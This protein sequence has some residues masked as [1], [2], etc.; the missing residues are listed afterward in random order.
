MIKQTSDDDENEVE[1]KA[2]KPIS[3]IKKGDKIKVD[4][5][6][7]EVD[8]HYVLIEHGKTK[9]M[10]IELFDSKTDEDFQVRYFNDNVENSIE[11]YELDEIVYNKKEIKKIEW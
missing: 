7:L 5:K 1:I 3:G 10:T 9:E 6:I 4:G 8:A 11:F 2:S